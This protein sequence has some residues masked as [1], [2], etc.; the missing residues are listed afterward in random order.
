MRR[1][2]RAGMA[3]MKCNG[4]VR[5]GCSACTRCGRRPC[6]AWQGPVPIARLGRTVVTFRGCLRWSLSALA[7]ALALVT[8]G[9]LVG[10]FVP[11]AGAAGLLV[12]VRLATAVRIVRLALSCSGPEGGGPGPEG[13][14]VREPRRPRPGPPGDAVGLPLPEDAPGGVAALA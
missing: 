9:A 10:M 1:R 5:A 6:S 8:G 13:A 12:V 14:G 4:S 2:Q 3:A 11:A 7:V